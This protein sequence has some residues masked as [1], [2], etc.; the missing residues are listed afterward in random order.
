MTILETNSLCK[1]YLDKKV[2]D[3][4][5]INIEKGKIVGLLG[6]NG[7]GKTTFLKIIAGLIR[8]SS[9]SITICD[10]EIGYKSK[11]MVAF[12]PDSDFF[13]PWMKIADIG[14]VY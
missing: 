9:G 10:T 11:G 4:I 7:S 8:P 14:K 1:K 12:L 6:P 13:Y 3:G 2:L 5:T